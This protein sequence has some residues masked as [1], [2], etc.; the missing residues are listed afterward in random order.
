M[1]LHQDITQENP[2]TR[3]NEQIAKQEKKLL[4][5]KQTLA[6]YKSDYMVVRTK[7]EILKIESKL[8]ALEFKKNVKA[9]E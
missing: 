8:Q 2:I 1:S 5:K 4:Q 7:R 6:Y 3:L 9:A